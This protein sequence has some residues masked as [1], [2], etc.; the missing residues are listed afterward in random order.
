MKKLYILIIVFIAFSCKT[1][2]KES[3]VNLESNLELLIQ[4]SSFK[5]PYNEITIT[6][7]FG[8]IVFKKGYDNLR[9]NNE[10]D[11]EFD[12]IANIYEK[13]IKLIEGNYNVNV[14]SIKYDFNKQITLFR[15]ESKSLII[16]E[17]D[18]RTNLRF[19]SPYDF[20]IIAKEYYTPSLPLSSYELF[21]LS[22]SEEKTTTVFKSIY[23]VKIM[24]GNEL[25]FDDFVKFETDFYTLSY[26]F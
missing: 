6:N 11:E 19:F 21:S 20:Y 1:E 23:R 18:T 12:K 2:L 17:K 9:H 25:K 24:K 26:D 8:V 7:D 15:G 10:S 16:D 3:V 4:L 14:K 5:I 13:D 22:D